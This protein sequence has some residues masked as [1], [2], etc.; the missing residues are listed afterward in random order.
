LKTLVSPERRRF[1]GVIV[2][3]IHDHFLTRQWVDF[4]PV[5]LRAFI[6]ECNAALRDHLDLLPGELADTLEERI[7]DD[8]LGHYGSDDGLDGVFHR[9]ALRSPRFVPIRGAILDLR[10][11]RDS[12]EAGFREFFPELRAWLR[13]LGPEANV[14]IDRTPGRA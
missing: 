7:A 6:G 8:W 9:I 13:G 10:E 5:P 4:C 11:H 2:D 3:V 1:A 12:F 14:V